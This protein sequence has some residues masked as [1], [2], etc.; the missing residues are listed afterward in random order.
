[1]LKN[2]ICKSR[3]LLYGACLISLIAAAPAQSQEGIGAQIGAQIDRGIERLGE[4]F[5]ESWEALQKTVDNMGVQGRVY[6]RL[7]WDKQLADSRIDV[8][9]KEGG[10]V[11][12]QGRVPS[13]AAKEQ[14]VLLTEQTVGVKRVVQELAIQRP[15]AARERDEQDEQDEQNEQ[16]QAKQPLD[17]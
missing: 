5:R 13:E 17:V 15:P 8:D 3:S 2:S 7:K 4:E 14:A 16:P 10:I 1:V 11:L 6:S 12:L 9:V